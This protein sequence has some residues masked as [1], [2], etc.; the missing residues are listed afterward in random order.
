MCLAQPPL[1]V[2]AIRVQGDSGEERPEQEDRH[3]DHRPAHEVVGVLVDRDEIVGEVQPRGQDAEAQ[4]QPQRGEPPFL[5]GP[6]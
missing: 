1:R 3:L 2:E 6:D 4:D 5:Y